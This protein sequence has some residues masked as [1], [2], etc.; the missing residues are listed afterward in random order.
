M[1]EEDNEFP[2]IN[3]ENKKR[4]KNEEIFDF[5]FDIEDDN[6]TIDPRTKK[7]YKNYN[8]WKYPYRK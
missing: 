6:Y 5:N 3:K 7:K 4:Q 1:N 8:T 2:I